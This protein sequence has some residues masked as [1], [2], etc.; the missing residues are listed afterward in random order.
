MKALRCN[1]PAC[2]FETFECGAYASPGQTKN[3]HSSS[4]RQLASQLRQEY[5]AAVSQVLLDEVRKQLAVSVDYG[6]ACLESPRSPRPPQMILRP[7]DRSGMIQPATTPNASSAGSEKRTPTSADWKV[8]C[9]ALR[10]E[11]LSRQSSGGRNRL[12]FSALVAQLSENQQLASTL[13]T[14]L[15]KRA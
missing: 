4:D 9:A 10:A 11:A 13:G 12:G 2:E 15:S 14:L 8:I 1:R 3:C 6:E 7:M 5:F